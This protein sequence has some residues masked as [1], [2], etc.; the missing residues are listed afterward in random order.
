[1]FRFQDLLGAPEKA[2]QQK[3]EK[4]G[5][6]AE[7]RRAKKLIKQI[8]TPAGLPARACAASAMMSA[9]FQNHRKPSALCE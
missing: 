7:R 9:A 1:M 8:R 6:G 2:E 4:A 3:A 5:R